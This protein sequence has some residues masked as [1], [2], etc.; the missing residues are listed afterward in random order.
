MKTFEQILL[1]NFRFIARVYAKFNGADG[2]IDFF[3]ARMVMVINPLGPQL[4][5]GSGSVEMSVLPGEH[6]PS[7]AS[8]PA[9]ETA[10]KASVGK[11]LAADGFK[12]LP[13]TWVENMAFNELIDL[14]GD[15][16]DD[17]EDILEVDFIPTSLSN[18]KPFMDYFDNATKSLTELLVALSQQ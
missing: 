8:C 7:E 1:E 3:I 16:D 15:E 2:Q 18:L 10:L 14:Y 12:V 6:L 5:P 11:M 9:T 4:S 17:Y 13:K